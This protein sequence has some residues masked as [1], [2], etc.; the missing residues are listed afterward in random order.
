MVEKVSRSDV[1]SSGRVLR[2]YFDKYG[3]PSLS[4]KHGLQTMGMDGVMQFIGH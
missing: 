1:D 2:A 3:Y 4:R